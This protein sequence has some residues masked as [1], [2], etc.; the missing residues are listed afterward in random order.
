VPETGR[1]I[2]AAGDGEKNPPFENEKGTSLF[3]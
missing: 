3:D 1:G 2:A